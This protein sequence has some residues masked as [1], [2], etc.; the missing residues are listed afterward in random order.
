MARD[1]GEKR[2]DDMEQRI[3]ALHTQ[4]WIVILLLIATA[5][6]N[7]AHFFFGA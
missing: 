6:L 5:G 2:L 3:T 7:I 1:E 4:V